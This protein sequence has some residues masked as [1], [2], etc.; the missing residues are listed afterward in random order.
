M[1]THKHIANL[2]LLGLGVNS[3]DGK[4]NVKKALSMYRRA[5]TLGDPKAK[6]TLATMYA[7]GVPGV[8]ERDLAHAFRYWHEAAELAQRPGAGLPVASDSSDSG[9][10]TS[11]DFT[12]TPAATSSSPPSNS[13]A[14]LMADPEVASLSLYN[15][16]N[17]Y[18][19]GVVAGDAATASTTDASTTSSSDTDPASA[20]TTPLPGRPNY[21]VAMRY[22]EL[23]VRADPTNLRAWL[24]LGNM[25]MDG[26]GGGDRDLYKA[27]YYYQRLL[28]ECRR[29]GDA[30][31]VG[32]ASDDDDGKMDGNHT[33]AGVVGQSPAA[34]TIDQGDDRTAMRRE[35]ATIAQ[36]LLDHCFQELGCNSDG[37]ATDSDDA[38]STTVACGKRSPSSSPRD[39]FSSMAEDVTARPTTGTPPLSLMHRLLRPW[40]SR[41]DL[42]D[43][44]QQT[45]DRIVREDRGRVRSERA[46]R[47]HWK[48]VEEFAAAADAEEEHTTH[49][50]T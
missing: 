24:Q 18:F 7:R 20:T 47:S 44:E 12:S 32:V 31:E 4:P 26:V 28:D 29:A 36:G 45:M 9:D 10:S 41:E 48:Y 16:G 13:T 27:I 40:R 39:L 35:V 50:L 42:V 21:P 30:V 1:D 37:G 2:Y 15:L 3:G 11:S 49:P 33:E 34:T 19:L 14:L 38:A 6:Y 23:A 5:S 43:H 46:R 25:Y 8:L 17:C 22:W